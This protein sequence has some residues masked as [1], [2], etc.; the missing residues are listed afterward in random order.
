MG[1]LVRYGGGFN[2]SIQ[3]KGGVGVFSVGSGLVFYRVYIVTCK[4]SGEID[5]PQKSIL[6]SCCSYYLCLTYMFFWGWCFSDSS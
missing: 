5:F 3:L 6:Y 1:V 4:V 2:G